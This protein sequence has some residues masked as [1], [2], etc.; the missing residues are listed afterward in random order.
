LPPRGRPVGGPSL[1]ACGSPQD[2][3]QDSAAVER[4]TGDEVEKAQQQVDR[5]EVAGDH[6]N[7]RLVDKGRHGEGDPGQHEAGQWPNYRD[8]EFGG[9]GLGIAGEVRHATKDEQRYRRRLEP[10][11]ARHER[12]R[13]LVNEDGREQEQRRDRSQNPELPVRQPA[14]RGLQWQLERAQ[15]PG[16]EPENDQPA[17]VD[18]DL[19][20]V[21]REKTE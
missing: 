17:V 7:P 2:R 13:Q 14:Q 5:E 11:G 4:K 21:D 12:V 20:A 8:Q 10:S 16:H 18:A 19:N 15:R 9:G 1:A 6:A 3:A